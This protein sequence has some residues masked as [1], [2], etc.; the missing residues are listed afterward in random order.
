MARVARWVLCG[1][2]LVSVGA[3]VGRAD[4]GGDGVVLW[5]APVTTVAMGV[6]IPVSA[7]QIAYATQD[8]QGGAV[9][10]VG[11]LLVPRAPWAGPGVRPLLSYQE[12][13]DS[14]A[15]RC[16]VSHTL[17]DGFAAPP[18]AALGGAMV[19]AEAALAR[20]WAV[21]AP[22]Y[23][24]PRSE[25][26]S[27][28]MA[29]HAVLDGIRAALRFAPAGLSPDA[30]VGVMGY[31]GGAFASGWAAEQQ[32]RYA[33]EINLVGAALGGVPGDLRKV[34]R[35]IDGGPYAGFLVGG[36]IG[37]TR[38]F[39]EDGLGSI[40]NDAGRQVVDADR[41]HCV[42]ELLAGHP[43]LRLS[44]LTTIPDPIGAGPLAQTLADNSLGA[45][46][47][48]APVLEY[49]ASGDE[50]VTLPAADTVLDRYC[51]A[52]ATVARLREP[53]EHMTGGVTAV[54][55][56]LSYLADRFAG[57]AAPNDC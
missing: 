45:V 25:F 39:P 14:V 35:D 22:D 29:A 9:V 18:G 30:P 23:E 50:V 54:P 6:P 27:G 38:A 48:R 46:T 20:G 57:V 49:H 31:S 21:I 33:P 12:A 52:G 28:P 15:E 34:F 4:G 36:L 56:L 40:L 11:T 24:G 7:W 32:A 53:G 17:R 55:R 2:L 43:F 37:L 42:G 51:A 3:G 5:A 19:M 26:F 44:T 41:N 16:A 8:A 10:A 13:E 47:P 1:L